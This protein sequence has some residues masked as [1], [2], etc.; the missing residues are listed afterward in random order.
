M[1]PIPLPVEPSPLLTAGFVVLPFLLVVFWGW[2]AGH[3]ASNPRRNRLIATAGMLFL[4]IL[5]FILGQQ[6][7]LHV[8]G[9]FPPPVLRLFGVGFLL[10]LA[11]GW[12]SVGRRLAAAVPLWLLVG[13]Q[14]FRL[15][16]ELLMA[17][18]HAEGLM[19]VEMSF[20]GRN[21]DIVTGLLALP[22]SF[23]LYRGYAGR[24]L[25]TLWNTLGL[26]LLINVV[27]TAVA[28]MPGDRQWLASE[29]PN[30]WVS[31]WPFIWLP[32]ILV[33]SAQLG[34]ILVMRRLRAEIR[35]RAESST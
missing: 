23:A 33:T 4:L 6:P 21:F 34:H 20:H 30:V 28:I 15:P 5:T 35:A 17:R 9:A 31:Y 26:A 14:A 13:F 32:S 19:P 3:Q 10:T 7:F 8:F 11:V 22:L 2:A 18:A 16:L 24:R 1:N 12:S 29:I 27:G 25:V